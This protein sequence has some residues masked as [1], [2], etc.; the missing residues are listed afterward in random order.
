MARYKLRM[1]NKPL[2]IKL[3]SKIKVT[4][5]RENVWSIF[6]V[7]V[8]KNWNRNLQRRR[9]RHHDNQSHQINSRGS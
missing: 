1:F 9:E 7:K 5:K 3:P 6:A 4:I 2:N 8:V